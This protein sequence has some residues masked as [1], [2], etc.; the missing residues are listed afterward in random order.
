MNIND[1]LREID[2]SINTKEYVSSINNVSVPLSQNYAICNLGDVPNEFFYSIGGEIR[3]NIDLE[4]LNSTFDED[5]RLNKNK[6]ATVLMLFVGK[7]KNLI[8][9]FNSETRDK[10]LSLFL[11]SL[12]ENSALLRAQ[13]PSL[14]NRLS[15]EFIEIYNFP[16]QK[17]TDEFDYNYFN[18]GHYQF[19]P[20]DRRKILFEHRLKLLTSSLAVVSKKT[21][22][23][24]FM[25]K[26]KNTIINPYKES[27]EEKTFDLIY[28]N[29]QL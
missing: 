24:G 25:P 3:R 23:K 13:S 9:T 5:F 11:I 15:E 16:Y 2:E 29:L 14:T 7:N 18:T 17:L 12:T 6:L 19:I 20:P 27:I 28:E 8:I 1:I 21:N 26:L 10:D 22:L 4:Y